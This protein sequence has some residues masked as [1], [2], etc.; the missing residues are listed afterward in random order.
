M[1]LEKAFIQR[2]ADD[3]KLC[4]KVNNYKDFIEIVADAEKL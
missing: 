4:A 2:F 3:L 1:V